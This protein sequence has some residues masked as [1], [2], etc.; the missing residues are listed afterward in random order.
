MFLI[1]QKLLDTE[2]QKIIRGEDHNGGG[3]GG[4]GGVGK[5]SNLQVKISNN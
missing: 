2:A 4:G 3:G 5:L 1:L